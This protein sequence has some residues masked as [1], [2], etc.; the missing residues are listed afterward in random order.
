MCKHSTRVKLQ[1]EF[2][3]LF[4]CTFKLNIVKIIFKVIVVINVPINSVWNSHSYSFSPA[5]TISRLF[6]ISQSDGCEIVS[7]CSFNLHCPEDKWDCTSCF[8]FVSVRKI[9][10]EVSSVANLPLFC[11]RK[12]VAKLTSVPIFLYFVCGM[13]PPQHGLMSS[14]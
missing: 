10:P 9:G 3:V 5:V 12:I 6:N 8:V 13:L 14:V 11:L 1:V 2:L 7:H 4:L